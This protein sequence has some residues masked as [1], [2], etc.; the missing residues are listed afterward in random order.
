[1]CN[2][3]QVK[4]AC[5]ASSQEMPGKNSLGKVVEVQG[6]FLS[7]LTDMLS[8]ECKIDKAF[9]QQVDKLGKKKRR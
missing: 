5:S 8:N 1:M 6:N 2:Y 9:I 4:L 3:L 7:H